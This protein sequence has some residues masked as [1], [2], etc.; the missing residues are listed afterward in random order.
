M[1]RAMQESIETAKVNQVQQDAAMARALAAEYSDMP[2]KLEPR[3][4]LD[5]SVEKVISEP[6]TEQ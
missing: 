4:V 6:F 2:A 1:Q 5:G 3:V